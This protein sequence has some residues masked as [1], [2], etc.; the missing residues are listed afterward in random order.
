MGPVFLT[1]PIT[2][3]T[4]VNSAAITTVVLPTPDAPPAASGAP[5]FMRGACQIPSDDRPY[6][7]ISLGWRAPGAS[8]GP[9]RRSGGPRCARRR[10]AATVLTSV[11]AK[12]Q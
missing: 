7:G 9:C 2:L 8:P 3:K 5:P 11:P 10:G 6:G 4:R 12:D 1:G